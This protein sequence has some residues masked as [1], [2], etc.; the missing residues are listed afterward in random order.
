MAE[1]ELFGIGISI[2]AN[3][4]VAAGTLAL[5][6]F[7]YKSVK[8]SEEQV[9]FARN[10]IEKP[11]IIEKI[12]NVLNRIGGEMEVELLAIQQADTIWL[13]GSDQNYLYTIPLVFPISQKKEF[14]IG[15]YNLFTGPENIPTDE[16]SQ[17]ISRVD[18]NLKKRL[19]IY[20]LIANEF[21]HLERNIRENEMDR[22]VDVLLSIIKLIFIKPNASDLSGTYLIYRNNVEEIPISKKQLYDIIVSMVISSLF[23]PLEKDELRL[24][25]LGYG[26]IIEKL[27]PHIAESIQKQPIPEADLIKERVLSDLAILKGINESI[28]AD[29]NSMKEIY[30]KKYILTETELNPYQGMF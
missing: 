18:K 24:G 23:K 10:S 9:K 8:V 4:G 28:L 14:N 17:I 25:C 26:Y 29:I 19:E 2:I 11:R 21:S 15:F 1:P 12:H 6:I 3:L 27:F 13:I 20:R 22:R 16:F 30:R 7:T 5:A